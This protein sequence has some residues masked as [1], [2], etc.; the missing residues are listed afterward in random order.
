MPAPQHSQKFSSPA[1]GPIRNPLSGV[2]VIG[3]LT[4]RL[5]PACSNA[6]MRFAASSSHGIS[7]S[8]SGG[9]RSAS[10]DQSIPSSAHGWAPPV[11]YG[12]TISP[13]CSWR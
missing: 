7:R 6:G 11:S 2:C 10:N 13:C 9:S 4:I 8:S 1:A 12:P 3:P 5:I